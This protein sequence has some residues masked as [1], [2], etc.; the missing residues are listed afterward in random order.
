MVGCERGNI[1]N[2]ESFLR[3]GG[4]KKV[5]YSYKT[6]FYLLWI[7]IGKILFTNTRVKVYF[8]GMQIMQAKLPQRLSQVRGQAEERPSEYY[9]EFLER[10]LFLIDGMKMI[11]DRENE[12]YKK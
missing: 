2:V 7:P 10:Q 9:S 5:D 3:I 8:L 1:V 11:S 4:I 6:K 12:S